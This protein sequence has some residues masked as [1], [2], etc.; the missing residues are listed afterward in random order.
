GL[1][2]KDRGM[3]WNTDLVEA[4]EFD[5]LIAQ[6]AV[7]VNSAA[8]REESRGAH[9]REDFADRDDTNWMKHT[10]AWVDDG[11]RVSIDY[12]PIHDYT[13]SND[14]GYIEPKKRVY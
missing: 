5:N 10:L 1:D 3:V 9:A 8:N 2:V 7:T 13:M 14:V 6:A 4:L 11:G 12:R